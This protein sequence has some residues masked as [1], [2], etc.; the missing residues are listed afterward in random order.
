MLFRNLS[1]ATKVG[2]GF[3]AMTALLAAIVLLTINP[4]T[5]AGMNQRMIKSIR[6]ISDKSLRL[7]QAS[8]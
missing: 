1:T 4:H 6:N 5:I 7:S 3:A 2:I 8:A